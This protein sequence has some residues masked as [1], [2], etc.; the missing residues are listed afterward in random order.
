MF[1][2]FIS[3]YGLVKQHSEFDTSMRIDIESRDSGNPHC[4]LK[5]ELL[6]RNPLSASSCAVCPR[7]RKYKTCAEVSDQFRKIG[8][9]AC[10]TGE[11]YL[12][13]DLAMYISVSVN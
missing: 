10:F 13:K 3:S 12:C 7:I 1:K 8:I 11:I 9:G 4:K 5:P 6:E 2:R